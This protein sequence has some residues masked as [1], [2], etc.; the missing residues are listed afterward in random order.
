MSATPPLTGTDGRESVTLS[1]IA[2]T[3]ASA[4]HGLGD[5]PTRASEI[6]VGALMVGNQRTSGTRYVQLGSKY[7]SEYS[8]YTFGNWS[9][10]ST[11][12]SG[13]SVIRHS[14]SSRCARRKSSIVT[15]LP[16]VSYAPAALTV[17][18]ASTVSDT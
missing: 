16:P 10:P 1:G 9:V 3:T 18:S 12:P 8:P 15:P 13:A 4:S 7:I 14:P 5:P 6:Q 17:A 11:M 2:L